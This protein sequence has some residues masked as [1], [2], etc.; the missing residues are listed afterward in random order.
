MPPVGILVL[1]RLAFPEAIAII[2][3][4]PYKL[5][6]LVI[7]L[8]AIRAVFSTFIDNPVVRWFPFQLSFY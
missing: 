5:M 7:A 6:V 8:L 4:Q 2:I 3:L 1:T